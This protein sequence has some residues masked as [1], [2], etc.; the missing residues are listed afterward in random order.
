MISYKG[1]WSYVHA[2]DECEGNRI[3]RLARDVAGQFQMLTGE[4]IDLFLDRDA[5]KWGDDW[6]GKINSSITDIAFF[7]PV[8]TPRYFLS[9]ECR[10]E[11]Q[12][13]SR[14]ATSLGLTELILPLLYVDVPG[15]SEENS[16]DDLITLIRTFQW[17]DWRDLRFAEVLSGEYRKAVAALAGRII[18][19]NRQVER[20]DT[21]TH[22]LPIEANGAEDKDD[23]PGFIDRVATAEEVLPK[24]VETVNSIIK[25]I[26]FIGQTMRDATT[27]IQS[28]NKSTGGFNARLIVARRV[29]YQLTKPVER[30][31][32][33]V[34]DFTSHLHE[35]DQGVRTIIE[36]AVLEVE[37]DSK[38]RIPV[39]EFFHSVRNMSTAMHQGLSSSQSMVNAI[40]PIENLSRDLRPVLRKLRQGLTM[41]IEARDISDEWIKLVEATGIQ[42]NA[43]SP[44]NIP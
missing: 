25:D 24:L 10:R 19:A 37:R 39:C 9:P 21:D 29:A 3:S 34:N 33:L 43:A 36:H 16:K 7:I 5:I 6:R 30:I 2:D 40:H 27:D 35:V 11:L 23:V 4:K 28:S 42:C 26:E 22:T 38:L 44:T 8:L 13:F 32:S 18:E 31:R 17:Q 41:M 14:K 15:L 1:F 20:V 12:F